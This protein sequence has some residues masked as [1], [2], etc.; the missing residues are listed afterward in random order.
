MLSRI[1]KLNSSHA[2][3]IKRKKLLVRI[4]LVSRCY[5]YSVNVIGG[6][7]SAH[8]VDVECVF[9][10]ELVVSTLDELQLV[11]RNADH[12]QHFWKTKS[13]LISIVL[14]IRHVVNDVN[15][16]N[17]ELV[18]LDTNVQLLPITLHVVEECVKIRE[19]DRHLATSWS[20]IYQLYC[21]INMCANKIK[22]WMV[23]AREYSGLLRRA[24]AGSRR[25][26]VTED[27]VNSIRRF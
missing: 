12:L 6:D 9:S 10:G 13:S 27:Y 21:D 7:K 5:T 23:L 15:T 8:L 16:F 17:N 18:P 4:I 1:F 19:Q 20:N 26:F 14:L 25:R 2:K 11:Q 24:R 22:R 3:Q